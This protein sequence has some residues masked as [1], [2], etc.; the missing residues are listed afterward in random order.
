MQAFRDRRHAGRELGERVLA[1]AATAGWHD[2]VVL[3]LARGGVPVAAE[4][5]AALGA[6]LDVLV[7][8]KLGAPHQPELALGAVG[9]LV[10]AAD[11]PGVVVWNEE[12]V[13]ASGLGLRELRRLEANGRDEAS[14]RVRRLRSGRPPIPLAG[15][16]AVLVDDGIATGATARAGAELARRLGA[17]PVVLAVP[18]AAEDALAELRGFD[19]VICLATPSPFIA[20]GLYYADFTQTGDEEVVALL[21]DAAG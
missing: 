2:P 20:V 6:P 11:A 3:G 17:D 9:E 15:R 4:V 16:S 7:V 1:R 19:E 12:L 13:R 5:A 14:A 21:R 8:R 18:V 10:G